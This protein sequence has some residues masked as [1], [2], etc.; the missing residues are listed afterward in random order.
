VPLLVGHR[1]DEVGA[2]DPGAVDDHRDVL[3]VVED[4]VADLGDRLGVA[5]VERVALALR[6]RA[7]VL[8]VRLDQRGG[9]AVAL[10]GE[11]DVVALADRLQH[12][13]RADAP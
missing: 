8:R 4:V 11:R 13:P 12:D 9:L 5:D 6:A 7:D 10:V 1:H 2:V 3:E